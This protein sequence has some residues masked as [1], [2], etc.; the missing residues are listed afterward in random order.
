MAE[1]PTVDSVM[2]PTIVLNQVFALV[3]SFFAGVMP[4]HFINFTLTP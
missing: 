1:M 4:P 2:H 3:Q